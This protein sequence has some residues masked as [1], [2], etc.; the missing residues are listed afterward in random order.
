MDRRTP[1]PFPRWSLAPLVLLAWSVSAAGAASGPAMVAD[2]NTTAALSFQPTLLTPVGDTLFFLAADPNN[3]QELWA[4]DGSDEGTRLVKDI[5]PGAHSSGTSA[6]AA[7]GGAL[8]FPVPDGGAT[9]ELWRSDGTAWGTRPLDFPDGAPF[10]SPYEFLAVG[11]RLFFVAEDA[12]THDSA[13]WVTDGT[14]WHTRRLATLIYGGPYLLTDVGG[15]VFFRNNDRLWKTDGTPQGTVEVSP[16]VPSYD[17]MVAVGSTLFFAGELPGSGRGRE[18]WR[19]DGTPN[20]TVMVKDVAPGEYGGFPQGLVNLDGAL[21][22]FADDGVHGLELW[23]SDGTPEGT[24]MVVEIAPGR[25]GLFSDPWYMMQLAP[26][27]KTLFF[28]ADDGAHGLELWR[29]DGTP[30]GTALVQDLNP[31]PAGAGISALAALGEQAIFVAD[32]GAHGPAL[33]ASEGGEGG[34]TLL[35]NPPPST[36]GGFGPGQLRAAGSRLFFTAAGPGGGIALW[37]TDGSAAGTR[38][39]ADRPF[40]GS[41]SPGDFTELGGVLMF[42]ANDGDGRDLWRSDG[43][44]AGTFRV[45]EMAAF[46][47]GDGGAIYDLVTLNRQ[48]YF[49]GRVRPDTVALWRS[50]GGEA[51]TVPLAEPGEAVGNLTRVGGRLF[52]TTMAE[53]FP[54]LWVSDGTAEGTR[55]VRR[56]AE[57]TAQDMVI[58]RVVGLGERAFFIFSEIG[59]AG[60]ALWTSDGTPEGTRMVVAEQVARLAVVNERLYYT[61]VR[62]LDER[63]EVTLWIAD[64][65]GEK[66][67]ALKTVEGPRQ[68]VLP[69]DQLTPVGRRLLFSVNDGQGGAELWR[70]NGTPSGVQPVRDFDGGLAPVQLEGLTDVQGVLYFSAND[71]TGGREL[72]RTD[73]SMTT[74]WRVRDINPGRASSWPQAVAG[75]ENGSLA[76]FAASTDASGLELWRTRG[77]ADSTARLAELAPG[78]GSSSPAEFTRI[79]ERIF[80]AADDGAHGREL[81]VLEA[82]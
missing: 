4:S 9:A 68:D 82:K 69:I 21:L 14:W 33:W 40:G 70:S 11:E 77:T 25:A 8:Y 61:T 50:D 43:S 52:F 45:K 1:R 66:G 20:G 48:L 46:W 23:R 39:V 74:A 81:W 67:R 59:D 54:A 38:V 60:G 2:I 35:A 80:F 53:H 29:S 58:D 78:P 24:A 37:S 71:A 36:Y 75:V 41:S 65:F 5:R 76:L 56:I 32:D 63:L 42:T 17:P 28:L 7:V 51:G 16:V 3:G 22:F 19:S 44:A 18:L 79:G 13:V 57:G 72:F 62:E 73:R 30:G 15:T 10:R 26:A 6:M 64:R 27:G 31:G 55:M 49:L 34:A 12:V 47:E